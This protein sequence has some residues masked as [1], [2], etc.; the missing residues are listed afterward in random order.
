[1]N[2][3]LRIYHFKEIDRI[4]EYI[5]NSH[6]MM[7]FKYVSFYKYAS[8][9]AKP[10]KIIK[11]KRIYFRILYNSF[12]INL[13]IL[14]FLFSKNSLFLVNKKNILKKKSSLIYQD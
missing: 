1:M 13:L 2:L 6:R 14:I 4:A 3:V 7:L 11:S 5:I 9:H 10:E 8:M 12:N